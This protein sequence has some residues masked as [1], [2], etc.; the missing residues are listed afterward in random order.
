MTPTAKAILAITGLVTTL[1]LSAQA[2]RGRKHEQAHLLQNGARATGKVVSIRRESDRAGMPMIMR[3]QFTPEGQSNVV[4]GQCL[5]S[6]FSPYKP[7]DTAVVCY[8]KALPSSSIILSPK[9][10]PL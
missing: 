1:I 5:A 8:N 2:S 7:G 9:G 4:Q 6:V 10:K 3:Y